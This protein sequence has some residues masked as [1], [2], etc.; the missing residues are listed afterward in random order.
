MQLGRRISRVPKSGYIMYNFRLEKQNK[1]QFLKGGEKRM[2]NR[3]WGRYLSIAAA[4]FL[5]FTAGGCASEPAAE[6]E[7]KA[8]VE[9]VAM[10]VPYG[11]EDGYIMVDQDTGAV[12]TVTMP[13]EIYDAEGDPIS[14]EDLEKGNILRILGDGIM[15]ES[16]PGQYPGVES[17]QVEE[18]GKP[19]DADQYQAIVDEIYQEPDPSEVPFMN[20]EYKTSLAQVTASATTGGYEWSYEEKNGETRSEIADTAHI[21]AW[22]EINEIN[23]EEP[24]DVTLFFSKAPEKVTA[25][26]WPDNPEEEDAES[27]DG[28]NVKTAPADEQGQ[29]TIESVEPGYRYLIHAEWENGYVEYG[30]RTAS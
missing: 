24:T 26:R 4:A 30:F 20:V 25:L 6:E 28:E 7:P 19:S 27:S 5:P 21:T 12:F 9:T 29:F 11:T 8:E 22:T 18:E 1:D 13:E 2:N 14:Q 16:Y 23:I 17:I 10:Y 15:L 3:K